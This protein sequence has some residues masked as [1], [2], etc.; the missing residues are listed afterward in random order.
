MLLQDAIM[1]GDT[2]K[3][4]DPLTWISED[5][6]CGCAF[7]G[8]LLAA[9]IPAK[10]FHSEVASEPG[11]IFEMPCVKANWPWLTWRVMSEISHRYHLVAKGR[12]TIEDVAAY[13]K[14]VEPP[15]HAPAEDSGDQQPEESPLDDADIWGE[16]GTGDPN[17]MS[18]NQHGYG[19]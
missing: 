18:H 14:T 11:P 12:A 2:L 1:L 8:A 3:K 9:G 13:V 19:Q 7:G 5:G 16:C 17:E 6:S 15:E 4:C 10:T